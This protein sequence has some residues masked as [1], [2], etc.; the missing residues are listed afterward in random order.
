MGCSGAS[1]CGRGRAGTSQHHLVLHT[2]G[3]GWDKEGCYD[4][5]GCFGFYPGVSVTVQTQ[6]SA[7]QLEQCLGKT[8]HCIP[9]ARL[10]NKAIGDF[11]WEFTQSLVLFFPKQVLGT[12][13]LFLEMR[14]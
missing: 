2:E 6:E 8:V 9:R 5:F 13:A 10:G 3:S 14:I 1:D 4:V 7:F 11:N 12:V